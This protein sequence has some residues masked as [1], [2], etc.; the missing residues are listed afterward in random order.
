[1]LVVELFWELP[2]LA[3]LPA[4][5]SVLV[6]ICVATSVLLVTSRDMLM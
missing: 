6:S 3:P 5:V 1:M 2:V 4:V